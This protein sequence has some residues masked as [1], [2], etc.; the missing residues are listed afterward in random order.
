SA[1]AGAMVLPSLCEEQVIVWNEKHG[2]DLTPREKDVVD[3][4]NRCRMDTVCEDAEHYL[5]MVK[6][7]SENASIPVIASLNGESAGNWL[8][9]TRELQ[10]HG[11]SGIELL[12]HHAPPTELVGPAEAENAIV[13]LVAK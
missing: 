2:H 11:A 4:V 10:T 13:D 3:S 9:F 8:G 12:I 7:A 5:A 6:Q 1:G